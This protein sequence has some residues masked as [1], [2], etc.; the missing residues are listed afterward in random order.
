[1]NDY[2]APPSE[3][4]CV[5]KT[6]S[7]RVISISLKLPKKIKKMNQRKPSDT[8][9]L[10]DDSAPATPER[11]LFQQ[12][13]GILNNWEQPSRIMKNAQPIPPKLHFHREKSNSTSTLFM[14]SKLQ[15]PDVNE[16]IQCLTTALFWGIK[17]GFRTRNP[18]LDDLWSEELHPFGT[19]PLDLR[20]P[21]TIQDVS[22][23]VQTT[24]SLV[25]LSAEC[26]VMGIAYVDRMLLITGL[27][28][29]PTN[30]RRLLL[31]ALIIASK[32]WEDQ[33]VWNSDFLRAFPLLSIKDLNQMERGFLTK[34]QF[35]VTLKASVY[36]KYY[37][38]LRSLSER[39][40]KNFPLRPLNAAGQQRLEMRSKGLDKLVPPKKN[41]LRSES[42]DHY[43]LPPKPVALNF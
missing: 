8:D 14:N 19:L 2:I 24:F 43:Q 39:D 41:I 16:V 27:T 21:P 3:E 29:H 9:L 6:S 22:A 34:L 1:M 32:V 12:D 35:N 13:P 5:E 7:V 25:D 10:V 36:A 30:W 33:A 40:E 18:K 17:R 23:Y 31:G 26:G 28:L 4:L 15:A 37:F 42:T 38:E 20:I 11:E